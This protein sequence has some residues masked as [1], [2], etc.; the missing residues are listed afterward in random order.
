VCLQ[1]YQ[2]IVRCKKNIISIILRQ[3]RQAATFPLKHGIS[4]KCC[5]LKYNPQPKQ[6]Q[7]G[8]P[9]NLLLFKY[10]NISH[11]LFGPLTF[12]PLGQLSE[13]QMLEFK[14]CMPGFVSKCF[15]WIESC[16]IGI[17]FG[18]A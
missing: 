2:N 1:L 13:R 14:H 11:C 8:T 16:S 15:K 12:G 10:Q 17:I 6:S 3:I 5:V 7:D 18:I 4:S 9:N